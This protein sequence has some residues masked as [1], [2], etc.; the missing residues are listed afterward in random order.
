MVIVFGV[1][2]FGAGCGSSAP[3]EI[4][5]GAQVETEPSDLAALEPT[6]PPSSQAVPSSSTPESAPDSTAPGEPTVTASTEPTDDGSVPP[7]V[8]TGPTES[9]GTPS[10]LPVEPEP[11]RGVDIDPAVKVDA[12]A[13][14]DLATLVE[15]PLLPTRVPAWA[16]A[17]KTFAFASS[18]GNPDGYFITFDR[19]YTENDP[20][21]VEL[22]SDITLSVRRA[23]NAHVSERGLRSVEGKVRTYY[24]GGDV[25]RTCDF[26]DEGPDHTV[27]IWD[28]GAFTYLVEM[29]PLPGCTPGFTVEQ[30]IDFA[31]SLASCQVSADMVSCQPPPPSRSEGA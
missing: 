21:A 7:P 9:A 18:A 26:G 25:G 17:A 15:P 19:S 3:V 22:D 6:V 16:V 31:D 13:R 14:A 2:S 20:L 4:E 5:A 10:T 29:T 28:A 1:L 24:L 23:P 11:G 12:E 30:V 27:L 8:T